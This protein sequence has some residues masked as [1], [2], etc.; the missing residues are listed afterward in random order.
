MGIAIVCSGCGQSLEVAPDDAR[1]EVECLWCGRKTA[2]AAT[3]LAKTEPAPA[4]P[5]PASP[6]PASPARLAGPTPAQDIVLGDDVPLAPAEGASQR[7]R[8]PDAAAKAPVADAPGS[9]AAPWYEQQPYALQVD[10]PPATPAKI[11]SNTGRTPTPTPPPRPAIALDDDEDDRPY[12]LDG[13]QDRP[14]PQCGQYLPFDATFCSRCGYDLK[15]GQK[16]KKTYEPIVRTWESG[17]PLEMR[18]K[19]F[20]AGQAVVLS[21]GLI[22]LI[23]SGSLFAFVGP[24]V[25]FSVLAAY[26]LGTFSRV[27]LTRNKKGKIGL[28]QTWRVFFQERPTRTI[29][30]SEYEGVTSGKDYRVDF[31]DWLAVVVFLGAGLLWGVIVSIPLVGMGGM[32]GGLWWYYFIHL[33]N[34]YVAL[35]K[36]HGHPALNLYHGWNEKQMREM[37]DTIK[38]I[39]FS[40]FV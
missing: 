32:L 23:S 26:L 30:L 33:E 10:L 14:C 27:E 39:A 24:W 19:L 17:Y 15:S 12:P 34:Y 22:G 35:T 9:P 7:K 38:N 20:F 3:N 40:T 4:S 11:G 6:A 25:F 36:D 16:V 21:H 5:A 8:P 29:L 37:A 28:K 31:W 18:K 13:K 1:S 2:V